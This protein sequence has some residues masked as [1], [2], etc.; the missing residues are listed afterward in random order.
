MFEVVLIFFRRGGALGA[1]HASKISKQS[2]TSQQI[3]RKRRALCARP[4]TPHGAPMRLGEL[5]ARVRIVG[6]ARARSPHGAPM[7]LGKLAALVNCVGHLW[8]GFHVCPLQ[9]GFHV[10]LQRKFPRVPKRAPVETDSIK[11]QTWEP[12][13]RFPRLTFCSKV[14]TYARRT[15]QVSTGAR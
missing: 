11:R 10:K 15:D 5:A 7:R 8:K 13:P 6:C 2:Q 3:S 9:I 4:R 12:V 1:P 14:S